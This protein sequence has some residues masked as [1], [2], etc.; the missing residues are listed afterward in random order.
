MEGTR[1]S[2]SGNPEDLHFAFLARRGISL[3]TGA[4]ILDFGCGA[5]DAV[6][7]L[8]TRGRSCYGVDVNPFWQRSWVGREAISG[9]VSLLDPGDYRLPFPDRFFDFCFS[10]QVF[11][12]ILDYSTV[13]RELG[14]VLK[15]DALSLHRFPGPNC[16]VEAHAMLPLPWLCRYKTYLA[17]AALLGWRAADQQ[18][19]SWQQTLAE[20]RRRMSETFYPTK[21][22]LR[23]LAARAGVA[24]EFVEREEFRSLTIGR[25]AALRNGF[26]R[27]GVGALAGAVL[28]LFAQRYMLLRPNLGRPR[29]PD[30][31]CPEPAW[32]SPHRNCA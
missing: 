4:E 13:F 10:D 29:P 24:V 3:R 32:H 28:P 2:A 19:L 16:P 12:H 9:R 21:R 27:L 31:S 23:R 14:R 15:P 18:A 8:C 11:E 17:G 22:A 7:R 26:E 6:E 25:L 1:Q 30:Q 20:N 5:A